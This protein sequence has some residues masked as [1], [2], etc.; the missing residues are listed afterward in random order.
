MDSLYLE[1]V[2]EAES[3]LVSLDKEDFVDRVKLKPS[4]MEVHVLEF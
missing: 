1:M 3:T 2:L 4:P